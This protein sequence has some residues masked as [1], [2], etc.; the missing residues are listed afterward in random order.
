ME[1]LSAAEIDQQGDGKTVLTLRSVV[2]QVLQLVPWLMRL[3]RREHVASYFR[4]TNLRCAM[5]NW[6]IIFLVV[7]LVAGVLGFSGIAGTAT[8]IAWILF[9]VGLVMAIVFF[10]G[11][12]RP[13][14][15]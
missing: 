6:A 14:S 3:Q 7:A 12:R 4:T 1:Y 9:V 15:L 2:G 8:Q 10:L 11:G 5:F 13:P